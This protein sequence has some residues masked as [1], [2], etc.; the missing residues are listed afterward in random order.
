[1]N[2]T[3]TRNFIITSALIVS[4]FSFVPVY[5]LS[6]SAS[7]TNKARVSSVNQ[8]VPQDGS[9]AISALRSS[10]PLP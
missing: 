7:L 9:I 2:A 3:F 1:M 8:E 4:A 10:K 6:L 5:A